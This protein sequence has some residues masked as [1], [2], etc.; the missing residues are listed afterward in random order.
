[1]T[2]RVLLFAVA[3]ERAGTGELE[4]SLPSPA[5]VADVRRELLAHLPAE[6]LAAS[7][8]AVNHEYAA[9]SQPVAASDEVAVI[10]PVSGG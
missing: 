9:D 1:M 2:V 7:A 3:R 6:L 8:V 5:T 10:P 4:L